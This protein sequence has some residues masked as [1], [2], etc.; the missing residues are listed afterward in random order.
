[1]PPNPL[2]NHHIPNQ[3][4]V[5]LEYAAFSDTPRQHHV[6]DDDDDDEDILEPLAKPNQQIIFLGLKYRLDGGSPWHPCLLN[7]NFG[8]LKIQSPFSHLPTID[9]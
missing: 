8:W 9:R 3:M 4:D 7:P 1:M 2:L 5:F 6:D